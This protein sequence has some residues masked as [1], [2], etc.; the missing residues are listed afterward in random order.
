MRIAM[1]LSEGVGIWANIVLISVIFVS[2]A[3]PCLSGNEG[4]IEVTVFL[5]RKIKKWKAFYTKVVVLVVRFY[6]LILIQYTVTQ[7]IRRELLL[8]QNIQV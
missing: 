8:W 7:Y 3:V 2:L 4:R 1:R 5:E 6:I